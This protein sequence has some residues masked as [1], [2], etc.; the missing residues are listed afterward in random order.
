MDISGTIYDILEFKSEFDVVDW[1]FGIKDLWFGIRKIP[2]LGQ[3]KFGHMKEPFSLEGLTSSK[4]IN[5][6]ER[7][8]PTEAFAPGR[9]GGIKCHGRQ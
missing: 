7:S 1:N 8:L 5:F 2:L 3:V 4:Y 9:N 6:M